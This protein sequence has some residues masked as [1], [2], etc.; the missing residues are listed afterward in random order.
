MVLNY[1]AMTLDQ[2]SLCAATW[3]IDWWLLLLAINYLVAISSVP[4]VL[5]QRRGT[6]HSAV[7]WLLIL[8][9]LPVLGNLLWW[10][11][12]RKH[13]ERQRRKRRKAAAHT[14]FSLT[15]LRDDSPSLGTPDPSLLPIKRM[16]LEE[17]EWVFPPTVENRLKLLVDATQAYPAMEAAIRAAQQHIHIAFYSWNNDATGCYWRD[18]LIE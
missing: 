12:G 8:F 5:L 6:P 4:S 3:S 7:S 10:A 13:L 2:L 18:L 16:P 11:I 17:A 14:A 1:H 9:A 15:R